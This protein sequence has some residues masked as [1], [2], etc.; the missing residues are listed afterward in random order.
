LAVGQFPTTPFM[1]NFSCDLRL[2]AEGRMSIHA[3]NSV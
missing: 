3:K 1:D 2:T